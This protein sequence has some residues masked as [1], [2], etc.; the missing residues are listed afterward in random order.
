MA[1]RFGELRCFCLFVCF[2]V[3]SC[4]TNS[5]DLDFQPKVGHG[6][7]LL[8]PRTIDYL[9]STNYRLLLPT[10][11]MYCL[12]MKKKQL[13]IEKLSTNKIILLDI[14]Y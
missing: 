9:L 7:S 3:S 8:S 11:N 12:L 13:F 6:F 1:G 10:N 14:V 5:L 2:S 4:F